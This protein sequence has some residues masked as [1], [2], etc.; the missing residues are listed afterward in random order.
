[1]DQGDGT[2]HASE[3][4]TNPLTRSQVIANLKLLT[5]ACVD[6]ILGW[7]GLERSLRDHDAAIRTKLFEAQQALLK[8]SIVSG[9]LRAQLEQAQLELRERAKDCVEHCQ[10]Q[11]RSQMGWNECKK[12]LAQAHREREEWKDR[13]MRARAASYEESCE[14]DTQLAQQAKRIEELEARHDRT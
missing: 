3:A 12:E 2:I 8:E 6:G 5:K 9:E 13:Y 1:M 10:D 4:M 7:G 14:R 11:A